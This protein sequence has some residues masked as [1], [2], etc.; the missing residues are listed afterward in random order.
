MKNAAQPKLLSTRH[1]S[2]SMCLRNLSARVGSDPLLVQASNGNTSIK[3]DGILW[4]KASGSCLAQAMRE[5]IFVPLELAGLKES[6]LND[7]EIPSHFALNDELRPSIETA[8]HAVLRHRVVIHVHSINAI[9]WA[10]RLD[11]RD[12]LS[13]RLAGLSWQWIPYTASGIPLAREIEKAVATAPRTDVLILGNHG[14]VVCGQDCY[15]AEK[16]LWEVERRLAIT[17][18]R[19]PMPDT[20]VLTMIARFSRWQFPD[21]KTLHALGTDSVSRKILKGGILYP[22]Q[23]IFLGQ[24]MPLL[25]P[26]AAVSKIRESWKGKQ[27]TPPFVAVERSGV[28]VNEKMTSA[29][30]AT[31]MGLVHVTLRTEESA[32]LRY[33]KESEV[34]G[35]LSQGAH[36]YQEIL[37]EGEA[38][39]PAEIK[40]VDCGHK[41]AY[42]RNGTFRESSSSVRRGQDHRGL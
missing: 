16:L 41:M 33:L 38:N 1:E 4:I 15:A 3:L 6:I 37:V 19:F 26:A 42:K 13:E 8:M 9:A 25:P 12:Q 7:S 2:E 24:T 28:M 27:R 29:E 34:T 22:C 40:R 23:A 11:G 32:Q 30:R 36:G 10:I 35:I 31:L 17:P 21:V 20:T 5:E 14:L 39:S 18:R